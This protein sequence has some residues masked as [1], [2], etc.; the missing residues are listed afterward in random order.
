VRTTLLVVV[1]LWAFSAALI[2]FLIFLG[3]SLAQANLPIEILVAVVAAALLS[4]LAFRFYRG[5]RANLAK[6][7]TGSAAMIGAVGIA[8]TDLNP[9]G[10]VRVQGEFWKAV[11]KDGWINEGSEVEVTGVEN[12]TIYV[13]IK[14]KV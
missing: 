5:L 1:I 13:K 7:K 3:L 4:I 12:L 2:L 9:A 6:A 14:E 8:T 10:E 11:A